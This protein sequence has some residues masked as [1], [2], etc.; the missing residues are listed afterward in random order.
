[1]RSILLGFFATWLIIAAGAGVLF[2]MNR[3]CHGQCFQTHDKGCQE[4]CLE[5]GLCPIA[6]GDQ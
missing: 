5:R 4:R 3:Q 6:G 2:Y 1:M